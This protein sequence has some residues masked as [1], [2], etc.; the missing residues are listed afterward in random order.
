VTPL[1]EWDLQEAFNLYYEDAN[2]DLRVTMDEIYRDLTDLSQ[3]PIVLKTVQKKA[4]KIVA[5]W[6]VP[7]VTFL[8]I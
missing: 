6:K 5:N 3:S 7:Q 2:M 1:N 8:F 4:A